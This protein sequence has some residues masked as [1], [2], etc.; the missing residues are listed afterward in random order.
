MSPATVSR[1]PAG[2]TPS[3]RGPRARRGQ[4][5]QRL[6]VAALRRFEADGAVGA[7]LEDIRTDAGVST[8]ALYHHFPD[9]AALAAALYA[10]L[11]DDF[12]QGFLTALRANPDAAAGVR[13]GVRQ[14]LRWVGG[15]RAAARFLLGERPAD[16]QLAA[17][18][19]AF[20]SE[21]TAW[22][23]THVYY[24]SLRDLPFD[25]I[26]ALWLGPAHEY[27]RHW[28]AG[29]GRRVPA[30]AATALADA[31]WQTLKEER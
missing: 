25:V 14:Y 17:L 18:N 20:F 31:A 27:C 23:R 8:G 12:Q 19:A 21:V 7:T 11:L 2:A 4:A 5:R 24:G 9:K 16:A 30:A 15:N 1:R 6:L 10:E 28:L 26:N 3:R 22:W 29:T 13:A